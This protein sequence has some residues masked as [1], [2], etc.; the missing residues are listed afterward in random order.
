MAIVTKDRKRKRE[1]KK[2]REG[3]RKEEDRGGGGGERRSRSYRLGRCPFFQ[4]LCLNK[5]ITKIAA[6]SAAK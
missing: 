5:T 2:E 6:G 1:G 3:G 4:F